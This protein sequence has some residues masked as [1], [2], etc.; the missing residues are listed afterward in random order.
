MGALEWFIHK[1]IAPV[2][3]GR[4]GPVYIKAVLAQKSQFPDL[5][6]IGIIVQ[7]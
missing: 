7:K 3:T 2:N 6:P 4:K 5:V 1:E